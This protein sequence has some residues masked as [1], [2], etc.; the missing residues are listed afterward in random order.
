MNPSDPRPSALRRS[1]GSRCALGVYDGAVWA[2]VVATLAPLQLLATLLGRS[3]AQYL[4]ERLGRLPNAASGRRPKLLV[5]AVSVGEVAAA[6]AL[7]AALAEEC[8]AMSVVLTTGNRDGRAAADLLRRSHPQVE[9]VSYLPW[10]RY[11]PLRIWL[12]RLDP[13]AVIVVETEI[14]PNLF[15]AAADLSIPLGIV[16]GRM[17][18]RDACRYRRG[19]WFFRPVLAC[20]RWIG[21]QSEQDRTWFEQA[22]AAPDRVEVM[23]DLKHDV[24]PQSELPTVWRAALARAQGSPLIVAGSTHYPEESWL[25]EALLRVREHGQ[26]ARLVLAPR[27]P[28]RARAL[29][30]R[31]AAARLS[32]VCWSDPQL[33]AES[34]DMLVIDRIGVLEAVYRWADVVVVGGSMILRGGHNPLEAARYGRTIIMGPHYEHFGDVVAGLEAVGGILVLPNGS[35]VREKLVSA[36]VELAGNPGRRDDIGR[37]ALAYTESHRGV[38]RRYARSLLAGLCIEE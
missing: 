2:I 5:H 3:S 27:H 6:G 4:K 36:V 30:R 25:V 17:Y 33:A 12:R 38:A 31:A 32:A 23:G 37:R 7:I 9:S 1:L 22:G 28:A 26:S 19:R 24:A 29:K 21:V 20:A 8:K 10:D 11:R 13:D 35:K 16:S 18:P 15:R 14:W 34:W